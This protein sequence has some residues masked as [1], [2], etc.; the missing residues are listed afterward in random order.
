VLI[1]EV[2]SVIDPPR[3]R[4]G[5]HLSWQPKFGGIESTPRDERSEDVMVKEGSPTAHGTSSA[6]SS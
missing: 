2:Q 6:P 1:E 3:L 4:Q 5:S